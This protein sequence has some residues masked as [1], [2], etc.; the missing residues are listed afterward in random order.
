MF[1]FSIRYCAPECN[2]NNINIVWI[3]ELLLYV[4]QPLPPPYIRNN[5]GKTESQM[6]RFWETRTFQ[7]HVIVHQC[8][9]NTDCQLVIDIGSNNSANNSTRTF[10]F[11]VYYRW[12]A[13]PAPSVRRSTRLRPVL[14]FSCALGI[15]SVFTFDWIGPGYRA[16]AVFKSILGE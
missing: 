4:Y 5:E 16:V 11:S 1:I 2:I 12:T 9:D 15:L 8:S 7:I 6:W 10:L 14:W 3:A 13:V